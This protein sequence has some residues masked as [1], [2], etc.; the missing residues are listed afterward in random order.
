MLTQKNRIR[1]AIPISFAAIVILV[2]N[3]NILLS[4]LHNF[5]Q[6]TE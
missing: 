6:C 1:Q 3:Y 5:I 4:L 2:M